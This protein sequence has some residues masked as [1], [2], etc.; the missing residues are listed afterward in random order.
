ME[1]KDLT[2]GRPVEISVHKK[3]KNEKKGDNNIFISSLFDITVKGDVVIHM[4]SRQGKVVMLPSTVEY[5]IFIYTN[6]GIYQFIGKIVKQGK[7][8]TFPVY[9]IHPITE[10]K[11]IQRREF[12]RFECLIPTE[13]V[14]ISTELTDLPNM[15]LIEQKIQETSQL[16]YVRATIVN[17]SGGGAKIN[18]DKEIVAKEHMYV[19]FVL[20]TEKSTVHIHVLAR[21]VVSKYNEELD[22]YEN[23]VEFIFKDSEDRESIIKYI[24]DEDRRLRKKDQG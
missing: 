20:S 2:P 18:S 6:V 21:I 10:L 16:E 12:Y 15:E 5:D 19:S 9:V 1:L 3:N 14:G 13:V 22:I 23:R 7:L 17:L 4:P 8:E 11:K 24:F